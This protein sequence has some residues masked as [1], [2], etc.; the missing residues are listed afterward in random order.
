MYLHGSKVAVRVCLRGH[1]HARVDRRRRRGTVG[2]PSRTGVVLRTAPR[3]THAGVADRVALHLVDGH[4]CGV[5]LDELDETAALAGGD[6]DVSDFAET[7]EE[8]AEL[9]FSHVTGEATDKDGRVVGVGELIHGLWGAVVTHRWRAH[10]VHAHAGVAWHTAAHG[11][12]STA[13]TALVLGSGRRNAHGPVAAVDALHLV[14]SALLVSLIGKAN[15]AVAPRQAANGV[16]HDFG[17]LARVVL[18]LE[19]RHEDVLIDLWAE[20][21]NEDGE[22]GTTVVTAAVCKSTATGPVELKLTVRVGNDLAVELE[23]LGSGIGALEID[24][25]IASVTAIL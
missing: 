8:G 12:W 7:L 22:L 23:S 9:V 4:F 6:L 20:I 11:T 3:E 1:A 21:T 15:E 18:A 25:A 5:T 17:R 2:G 16:R 10:R 14:E 24:E 19:E 13:S